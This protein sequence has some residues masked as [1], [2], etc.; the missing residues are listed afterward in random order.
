GS[1]RQLDP[2]IAASRQLSTFIYA[3]GGD[4]E[5]YGIDG[6]AEMLDYLE[7]LGFPS[8]KERQRCSTIE[9][10]MAFIEHW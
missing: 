7:G 4:G 8:N 9:E 5:V 6:H 1:L 2:K 3:I 10:V